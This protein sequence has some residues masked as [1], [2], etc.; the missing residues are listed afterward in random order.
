MNALTREEFNRQ[1][2]HR[3]GNE[4]IV[5]NAP[6]VDAHHIIERRLWDDGGY[7][8]DNGVSLCS[9]HHL[10]AESTV[11][12]PDHLR[13]LAGIS[14]TILP[15]D[16]TE[17]VYD[18]WGNEY[19]PSGLRTRG[20]LFHEESVQKALKMGGFTEQDFTHIVKYPRTYHLPWSPEV[21]SDDRVLTSTAHFSGRHVVVTEKM[22][23]ENANLYRDHYHAR[24]SSEALG[25]DR[26]HV[27]AIWGRIR[28]DIP[29]QWRVCGENMAALHSVAYTDLEDWFLAFSI[30][31]ENNVA[32]D[33]ASTVEWCHLLGVRHVPV[34]YEGLWEDC[35]FDAIGESVLAR[36]RE[37]Y[38][39]RTADSF[40]YG[41]FGTS[42]AKFVRKGHVQTGGVH[43]RSQKRVWNALKAE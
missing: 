28:W 14:R 8:L 1:V 25:S 12:H 29:D 31:N 6:A 18:K 5:C 7:Y 38:V 39:V 42:I 3:D 17:G 4:C 41:E 43:W 40:G 32:L 16:L 34:L 36:G 9:Q 30:W 37:G 33:W 10:D 23:G 26:A 24:S 19:L 21:T 15:P 11:L 35:P 27:K 13:E 2:F 22:D 20:P